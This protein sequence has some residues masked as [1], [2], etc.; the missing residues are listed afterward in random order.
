MQLKDAL[1]LYD[2][3]NS[4]LKQSL[5]QKNSEILYL[6]EQAEKLK[7]ELHQLRNSDKKESHE[8]AAVSLENDLLKNRVLALQKNVELLTQQI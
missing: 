1:K 7:A 2:K 8:L 4:G 6:N 5:L 3:E